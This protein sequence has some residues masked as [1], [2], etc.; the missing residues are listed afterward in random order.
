MLLCRGAGVANTSKTEG[1]RASWLALLEVQVLHI[2]DENC[3]SLWIKAS[4]K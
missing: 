3:K 2:G 4:A 1:G